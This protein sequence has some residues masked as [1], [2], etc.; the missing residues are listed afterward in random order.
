MGPIFI[1]IAGA[2]I[3]LAI[4]EWRVRRRYPSTYD[5]LF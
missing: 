5:S 1:G 2:F 3:Y 4:A